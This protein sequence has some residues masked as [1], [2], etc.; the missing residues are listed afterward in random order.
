MSTLQA[1]QNIPDG[2]TLELSLTAAGDYVASATS[3]T[4]PGTDENWSLGEMDPGPK[5]KTLTSPNDYSIVV[6]VGFVKPEEVSVTV[7]ARIVT[8]DGSGD[9]PPYTHTLSG[10]NEET[11]RVDVICKTVK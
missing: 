7:G 4:I 6:H 11:G 3:T 9:F 2:S 1:W 5:K 10:T 8:P